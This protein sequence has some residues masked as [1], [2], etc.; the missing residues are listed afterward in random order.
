M[1]S[2]SQTIIMRAFN[3]HLNDFMEDIKRLFPENVKLR[4]LYNSLNSFIKINP[5]KAIEMWYSNI[6]AKYSEQIMNED[7][8]F[9]VNKNYDDDV[10]KVEGSGIKLDIDLVKELREPIMSI[11]AE[12][13]RTAI[14][15]IKEMTQLSSLYFSSQK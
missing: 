13:K 12:N 8:D 14:K 4:T 9:F 10:K 7:I 11:D 5:K 6:T 2:Q 15:Y 3:Q 1:T